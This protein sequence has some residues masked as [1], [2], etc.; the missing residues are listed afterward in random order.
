M[1]EILHGRLP[2]PVSDV[3]AFQFSRGFLKAETAQL[4][5]S[6]PTA[7]AG[8]VGKQKTRGSCLV[9][10]SPPVGLLDLGL[11]RPFPTGA[12]RP[13]LVTAELVLAGRAAP[14]PTR[15]Q[16]ARGC[17]LCP[18]L[19]SDRASGKIPDRGGSPEDFRPPTPALPPAPQSVFPSRSSP[20]LFG[21]TRPGH[22][23]A[24]S[25]PLGVWILERNPQADHVR[26]GFAREVAPG[27]VAHGRHRGGRSTSSRRG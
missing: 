24:S 22:C 15:P 8:S 11:H 13:G 27:R 9:R 17:A 5:G 6:Q 3:P 20:P 25:T 2:N 7:Q 19:E 21:S 16:Y 10:P 12:A 18:P 23:L 14:T 4:S 1:G 26:E